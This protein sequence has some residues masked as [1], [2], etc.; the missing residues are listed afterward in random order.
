M[1]THVREQQQRIDELIAGASEH[2]RFE[3][4]SPVDLNVLRVATSE[5]LQT[6][7]LATS[8]TFAGLRSR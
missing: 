8:I 2:W 1:I 4:L 7:P 6:P 3:R 5:L